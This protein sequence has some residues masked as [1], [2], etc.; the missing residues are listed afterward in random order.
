M[1]RVASHFTFCSPSVILKRAVVEQDDL[2]NVTRIFSLDEGFVESAHTQFFDGIISA[3]IISIKQ[4]INPEN[5]AN[6]V[7]EFHYLDLSFENYK[8][9]APNDSKRLLVDF[10]TN[11]TAEINSKLAKL[12][13]INVRFNVFEFIA[14]C[15]YYPA[16]LIGQNSE[17]Q[18]NKKSK[19]LLWENVDFTKM[20][21]SGQAKIREL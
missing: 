17:L 4:H 8:F 16:L 13:L 12:T 9:E 11:T 20:E 18:E 10:G 5:I 2:Q 3:E 19:L 15:V 7:S 14:A 21:F 6:L 1:K